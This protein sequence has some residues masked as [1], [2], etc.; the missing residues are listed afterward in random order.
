M[1]LDAGLSPSSPNF[2]RI[3]GAVIEE[4]KMVIACVTNS[5]HV[6]N[7]PAELQFAKVRVVGSRAVSWFLAAML[8]NSAA[9]CVR[10]SLVATPLCHMCE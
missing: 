3:V 9:P 7:G 5:F 2:P 6:L 4:C 8:L 1:D 10:A